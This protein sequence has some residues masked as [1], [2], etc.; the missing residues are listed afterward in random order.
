MMEKAAAGELRQPRKGSGASASA[1]SAGS[2]GVAGM[3][4]G[5]LSGKGGALAAE[6]DGRAQA[7]CRDQEELDLLKSLSSLPRRLDPPPAHALSSAPASLLTRAGDATPHASA[8]GGRREAALG[9]HR[10]GR[11]PEGPGPDGGHDGYERRLGRGGQARAGLQAERE[12]HAR[13]R[14]HRRLDGADERAARELALSQVQG[15]SRLPTSADL[16]RA[17]PSSSDL[18]WHPPI[19]GGP[20]PISA[21]LRRWR[22]RCATPSRCAR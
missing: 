7:A 9:Q 19:S 22:R 8:L 10:P 4:G 12:P 20:R 18:R 15:A 3:K 2:G 17:R 14:A 13:H 1:S 11:V 16:R 21:H 5:F 6:A